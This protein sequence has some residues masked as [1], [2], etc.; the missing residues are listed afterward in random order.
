MSA[1]PLPQLAALSRRS[2]WSL[3]KV[4]SFVVCAP[5]LPRFISEGRWVQVTS[6]PFYGLEVKADA[7]VIRFGR[8]SWSCRPFMG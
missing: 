8:R 2:P 3:L 6:S 5:P 1:P 7:A 4:S